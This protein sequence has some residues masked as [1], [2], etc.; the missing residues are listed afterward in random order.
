MLLTPKSFVDCELRWGLDRHF[1]NPKRFIRDCQPN[2]RLSLKPRLDAVPRRTSP[3]VYVSIQ[4]PN[5]PFTAR[6]RVDVVEHGEV[7]Y[8]DDRKVILVSLEHRAR[9]KLGGA[10]VAVRLDDPLDGRDADVRKVDGMRADGPAARTTPTRHM[11]H[12]VTVSCTTTPNP[13]ICGPWPSGAFANWA[14]PSCG[15][16]ANRFRTRSRPRPGSWPT[17]CATRCVPPESGTGWAGPSRRPRSARRC[18]S[19][20]WRSTSSAGRW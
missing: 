20:T 18:G 4:V 7:V 16:G 15:S 10:R 13:H 6:G 14:I 3:S 11:A 2:G 19:C 17:T 9:L 12:Y 5:Q 1:P 8:S